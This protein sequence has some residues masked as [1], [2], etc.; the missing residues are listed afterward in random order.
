[1]CNPDLLNE[2]NYFTYCYRKP[3]NSFNFIDFQF[4]KFCQYAS[5]KLLKVGRHESKYIRLDY[6]Q[7]AVNHIGAVLREK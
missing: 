2:G 7:I 6:F 4:E 3:T 1:M 5:I